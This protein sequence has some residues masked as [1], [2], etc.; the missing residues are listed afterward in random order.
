VI[1]WV[2]FRKDSMNYAP[3]WL[4]LVFVFVGAV[5]FVTS[6]DAEPELQF[7]VRFARDEQGTANLPLFE[8]SYTLQGPLD[9]TTLIPGLPVTGDQSGHTYYTTRGQDVYQMDTSSGAVFLMH[10]SAGVPELSWPMGMTYDSKRDRLLLVSLGGE[11]FLYAYALESKEWTLVAS[12]EN[13]DFA[14]LVYHAPDDSLY[15]VRTYSG[16]QGLIYKLA[17]DGFE[18]TGIV[19]PDFPFSVGQGYYDVVLVSVGEKLVLLVEPKD[20]PMNGPIE[21]RIYLIDPAAKSA[22]LTYQ[23]TWE[24]WPPKENHLPT[25][26]ITSPANGSRLNPGDRVIISA[27]ASDA[28]GTADIAAV[29]F[30]VN[31]ESFGIESATSVTT[32]D[33]SYRIEWTGLVA[34]TYAVSAKVT[35]KAGAT[36]R[37]ELISVLV[38]A[39]EFPDASFVIPT[40]VPGAGS[41][42]GVDF[43]KN[44]TVNGGPEGGGLLLPGLPMVNDLSGLYD[45]GTPF[46]RVLRVER[47]TGKV[48]DI[49][50]VA[51]GVPELSWP[52]GIASD[53]IHNKLYLVS[54]GGEGFLY[55]CD[56]VTLKWS[57]VS[58]MHDKDFANL[59]FHPPTGNLYGLRTQYGGGAGAIYVMNLQGQPFD[60]IPLPELPGSI[61]NGEWDAYMVSVGDYLALLLENKE[62]WQISEPK[63][64]SRI[65]VINP[66]T[67]E[68]RLSYQKFWDQWP[69]VLTPPSVQIT[70]PTTGTH[71]EPRSS[72]RLEAKATDDRRVQLVEFFANG[73]KLGNADIIDTVPA[74]KYEFSWHDVA[75]GNYTIT[76]RAIDNDG[77][78]S[79]SAP[80]QIVVGAKPLP[81]IEANRLLPGG[82]F[83]GVAFTVQ[84]QVLPGA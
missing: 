42:E 71:F 6:A 63:G 35:D 47:A 40:F 54:L 12:M 23:K 69:P 43:F 78:F 80:V 22:V 15:G 10:L 5:S 75:A 77:R 49:P 1:K 68:V 20:F 18:Q 44:Y 50:P 25:V 34:G 53:L 19:V 36:A 52:M 14:N 81:L 30:Y 17:A 61:P 31:G 67:K 73:A 37:S 28:D 11:G 8:R 51:E 84:I 70:A 57:V 27:T 38:K 58:S 21:S 41:G 24:N 56:P 16:G 60:E 82:Y 65:Y 45:Y 7:K 74:D 72:I 3:K 29:E 26:A 62:D 59:V 48:Q 64:E 79:S 55:S 33:G 2:S 46:Q 76:A 32:T 4:L 66:A 83:P 9:G 13:K 39:D